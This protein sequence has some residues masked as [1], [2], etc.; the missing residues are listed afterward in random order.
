[1]VSYDELLDLLKEARDLYALTGDPMLMQSIPI[2][3]SMLAEAPVTPG[4]QQTNALT[5]VRNTVRQRDALFGPY[6]G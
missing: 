1:M 4:L 3:A 6:K 5:Y 2:L